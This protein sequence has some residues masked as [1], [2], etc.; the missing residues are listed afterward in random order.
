MSKLKIF[1]VLAFQWR[2][3]DFR[4]YFQAQ[5]KVLS[6]ESRSCFSPFLVAASSEML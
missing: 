2:V 4:P 6:V 1:A 3:D 5:S